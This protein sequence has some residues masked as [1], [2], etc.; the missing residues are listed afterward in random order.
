MGI[1]KKNLIYNVTYQIL[2]I[3]LPFITAPYIS[4]V[5][6]AHDVGV[7]SY[8]QAFANYFY[9]FAMLGVMNYGNRTIAAVR[10][11]SDV[12]RK[13]FWE[14]FSF[15]FFVGMLVSVAYIFYCIYFVEEDKLIYYMQFFYVISGVFDINWACFGLEKFKL[16]TIRSVVVRLG[17]VVAI[18]LFVKERSDLAV[19]TGILSVGNLIAAFAVWPFVLKRIGFKMPTL[20]GILKHLKPNL[21]LFFPVIAVSIYHLMAR[22]MLGGLSTEEEVGFYTYAERITQIP[23]TLILALNSVVMPRMANLY[24]KNDQSTTRNLMDK[25]MLFAMFMSALMAFGLAGVAPIFAPWFYGNEFTRCGLFIVLL[26][27][28]IIFKGWA[29]VLRTQYI[30]PKGRDKVYIISLTTGAIVSLLL[31]F[32]LIPKYCGTGAVMGTL[33]AELSVCL[34]QFALIRREIPFA[35]YLRDGLVFCGFGI[36]MYLVISYM[37]RI[38]MSPFFLMLM[39]IVTGTLIFVIPAVFYCVKVKRFDFKML[40]RVF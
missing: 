32:L 12:L 40:K 1:I 27:P 33:G 18:F 24:A 13:T 11:N 31:N 15:Q 21:I 3:I 4:R 35:M 2:V 5:L 20:E 38:E 25:V 16:T 9:L 39:Q 30:I 7:Y 29:G 37:S 19:Y 23:N 26:C 14:I 36:V 10:D 17:M 34:V 22:L 8:T 6:G 28:I